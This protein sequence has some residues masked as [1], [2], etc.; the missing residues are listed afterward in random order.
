M[1]NSKK[2]QKL[3]VEMEKGFKVGEFFDI[4]L[5]VLTGT[6]GYVVGYMPTEI[7][8]GQRKGYSDITG[9]KRS[10]KN[11][12]KYRYWCSNLNVY[13]NK[14]IRIWGKSKLMVGLPLGVYNI[15]PGCHHNMRGVKT[16]YTHSMRFIMRA[17]RVDPNT[18]R[19]TP[20]LTNF[21]RLDSNRSY[22]WE[23]PIWDVPL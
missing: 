21:Q 2:L 12:E 16:N 10:H 4:W 17:L 14:I 1:Y 18:I 11:V 13:E 19:Q 15:E 20:Q 22:F 8:C 9:K 5:S 3:S 6:T 23:P 7:F